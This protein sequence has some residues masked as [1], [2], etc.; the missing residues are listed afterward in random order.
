MTRVVMSPELRTLIETTRWH[1]AAVEKA[2]TL[3]PSDDAELDRWIES[4]VNHAEIEAFNY[5]AAA[6]LIAGRPFA[7]RHLREGTVLAGHWELLG[8][9]G[10]AAQGEVTEALLHALEFSALCKTTR[11]VALLIAAGRWRRDRTGEMPPAVVTQARLLCRDKTI[12]AD[13]VAWTMLMGVAGFAQS[14][15]L[16]TLL[17]R[18]LPAK[19]AQVLR[20]SEDPLADCRAFGDAAFAIYTDSIRRILREKANSVIT[21]GIT[22]RRP[23]D[24]INRNAQCP[25]GSGK[26]YKRCCAEKDQTRLRHPSQVPGKT[27]SEMWAEPEPHLTVELLEKTEPNDI[28]RFDPLKIAP[29][30]RAQFLER[31]ACFY[32]LD[33]A[34][35]ALEKFGWSEDLRDAVDQTLFFVAKARRV[36]LARRVLAALPPDAQ[37]AARSYLPALGLLLV[38]DEPAELRIRLEAASLEMLRTDDPTPLHRI[39]CSILW[40]LPALGILVCRSVIPLVGPR[41]ASFIFDQILEARDRLGL[42]PDDPFADIL[43]RRYRDA[44]AAHGRDAEALRTALHRVEA[45]AAEVRHLSQNLAALRRELDRRENSPATTAVP[46]AGVT[47]AHDPQAISDLRLKVNELKSA[48]KERQEERVALRR[49]L[50]QAHTDLEKLRETRGS[51][52][53]KHDPAE[54]DSEESLILPGEVEGHQPLRTI[55]FPRKFHDTLD[56]VPRTAG[57]GALTLLGRLAAAEAGAFHGVVRLKALPDVYRV[58]IGIDYRLLFRLLPDRIAVVDLIPRQDLERRLKTLV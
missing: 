32:L 25:C 2:A 53:A 30:L 6:T 4:A 41:P 23:V 56:A 55:E 50:E 28:L 10:C 37:D 11:A 22:I 39:A 58:R 21:N 45:K 54:A 36:D 14:A 1:K 43:E 5:L 29:E 52:S 3:L 49:E 12:T 51:E 16:V 31:L 57:R 35:E 38:S 13:P 19:Q 9:Y 18:V 24:R 34:T 17:Q 27:Y 48:L 26:K 47:A 44:D 33:R 40:N 20:E 42:S 15:D 7:A 46:T 8:H